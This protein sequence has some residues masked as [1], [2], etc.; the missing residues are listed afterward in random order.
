MEPKLIKRIGLSRLSFYLSG[1][2]LFCLTK[3]SGVDPEVS[4]GSMGMVTDKATTPRA[5]SYTFGLT[6]TF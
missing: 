4:Y 2:N 3:Y 5:K 6:A 1:E